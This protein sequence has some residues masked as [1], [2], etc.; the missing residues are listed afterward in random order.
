M[1]SF[2]VFVIKGFTV[3]ITVFIKSYKFGSQVITP[4]P[5]DQLTSLPQMLFGE[6]CWNTEFRN[7]LSLV[8]YQCPKK[9]IWFA[10]PPPMFTSGA[11]LSEVREPVRTP[12]EKCRRTWKKDR[13]TWEKVRKSWEKYRRTWKKSRRTWEKVKRSWEKCRRTWKPGRR[14]WE[15]V[16]RTW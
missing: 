8:I 14:T 2:D 3:C 10:F 11:Y 16:R 13:R 6:L 15:K 1:N 12:A 9:R 5:L 4:E 7:V